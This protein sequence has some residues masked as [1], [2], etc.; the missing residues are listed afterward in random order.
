V[1]VVF[2]IVSNY[3]GSNVD[4]RRLECD[5]QII[6]R[7]WPAWNTVIANKWVRQDKDLALVRW[8]CQRLGVSHHTSLKYTFSCDALA[9]RTKPDA[10]IGRSVTELEYGISDRGL[11]FVIMQ[12]RCRTAIYFSEAVSEQGRNSVFGER[13]RG[14]HDY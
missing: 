1:A 10:P 11:L 4:S 6:E 7:I 3:E 12:H 13:I 5:R 9:F 14:G 8:V 2:G